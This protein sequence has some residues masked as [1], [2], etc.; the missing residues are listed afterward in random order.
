MA[1][2]ISSHVNSCNW[3]QLSRLQD[4]FINNKSLAFSFLLSELL[5]HFD[6]LKVRVFPRHNNFWQ[7][8][9]QKVQLI[10]ESRHGNRID[11]IGLFIAIGIVSDSN[12]RLLIIS[13]NIKYIKNI[14]TNIYNWP[15][16][17]QMCLCE[18]VNLR[19]LGLVGSG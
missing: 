15:V 4:L 10:A 13:R 8:L 18:R 17:F 2:H 1:P 3:C 6:W 19:Y 11:V 12:I 14:T 16:P 5:L 9:I 7:D